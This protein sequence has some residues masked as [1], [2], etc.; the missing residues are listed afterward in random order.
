MADL[1]NARLTLG[2]DSQLVQH[3][4]I[5]QQAVDNQRSQVTELE[6][7]VEQDQAEVSTAETQLS[8]TRIVS[9]IDGRAGLRL[10]DVGN[11]VHQGDATGLVVINQVRP[12]AV[13]STVPEGDV[14]AIRAALAAGRSRHWRSPARTARCSTPAP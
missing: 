7:K 13:I 8:Y 9:P 12:I 1:A 5:S 11:I 6:A 10:V 14:P 2:R 4:F 3:A